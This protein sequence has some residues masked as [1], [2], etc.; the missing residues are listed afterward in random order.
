MFAPNPPFV[1]PRPAPIFRPPPPVPGSTRVVGDPTSELGQPGDPRMPVF[2]TAQ[3]SSAAYSAAERAAERA[4]D[5]RKWDQYVAQ[6]QESLRASSGWQREQFA[7][8]LADAEKGRQNA[9][10]M[11]ELQASTSRYGTDVGRQNLLSQLEQNQKQFEV[12]HDLEKQQLGLQRAQTATEYLSTPDRWIQAG[13]FL[14]LSGRVLAGQPGSSSY[15]DVGEPRMK[16]MEDF[17]VLERGGNP[18]ANRGTGADPVNRAMGMSGDRM[19]ASLP[20]MMAGSGAGADD[21]VKALTQVIKAV[22]P[23]DDDGLND[24]DF[25]VLNV[26]RSLYR[27]NLTPQ[28][29]ASINS[30][31]EYKGMLGSAGRR[32]GY[33]PNEWWAQ[34]RRNLPGQMSPRSA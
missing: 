18:Y 13:Q 26:A 34:Q 16:T 25:A 9:W 33:N 30:S 32:L 14:N 23:S 2:S 7:A 12:R 20:Q 1:Q 19:S 6:I 15:N 8:Q 31:P 4:E 3:P 27:K 5:A 11:A 29:Q 28:Q 24:T 10:R 22:P 17:A 21:R